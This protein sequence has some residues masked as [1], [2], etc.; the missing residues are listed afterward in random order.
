[1]KTA[2]SIL[3]QFEKTSGIWLASKNK[4]SEEQFAGK[5]DANSWSIGQVYNHL[6]AG[7][8]LYHLQ[9]IAQCLDGRQVE[10]NGKMKFP[11]KVVFFLGS[12]PP[13]RIKVPPSET[14]TPKQPPNI[15]LMKTGLVKLAKM[16]QE[17]EQKLSGASEISKTAHPAFGFLNAREWFQLIEMHFRHHLRQKERIDRFLAN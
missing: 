4:Y 6:V 7:T 1:M 13:M 5:P 17:T 3:F 8:R 16:M 9:Q 15:D 2:Q 14:Y 12:I 10:R 11:G